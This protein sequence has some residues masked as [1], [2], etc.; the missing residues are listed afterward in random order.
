MNKINNYRQ[1]IILFFFSILFISPSCAA[2]VLRLSN[3]QTVNKNFDNRFGPDSAYSDSRTFYIYNDGNTSMTISSVT[4]DGPGYGIT[5]SIYSSPNSISAGGSGAITVSFNVPSSV[6]TGT[7]TGVI[8]VNTVSGGSGT[9]KL[10][11]VVTTKIPAELGSIGSRSVTI[12]FDKPKGSVPSFQGNESI[13]L[14][15]IGDSILYIDSIYVS[16]PNSDI[17]LSIS[18]YQTPISPKDS[19][20]A[21][22]VITAQPSAREGT[23][24]GQITVTTSKEGRYSGKYGTPKTDNVEVRVTIEHGINMEI[25][26]SSINFGDTELLKQKEDYI[27]I[28]ETLGYK[29]IKDIKITKSGP[30]K[31]LSVSP[32]S[33]SSINAFGSERISAKLLYEGDAEPYINHEWMYTIST[34]NAGSKS[35]KVSSKMI[36]DPIVPEKICSSKYKSIDD[37]KEIAEKMCSALGYGINTAAKTFKIS[38]LIL[39]FSIGSS[40]IDLLDSYIIAE[41][42]INKEEH[43]TAYEN[44][45]KGVVSA[46]IINTYAEKI[47]DYNVKLD[48]NFVNEKS[49]NLMNSLLEKETNYYESKKDSDSL[50]SLQ[51]MIAYERLSEMWGVLGNDEKQVHYDTLAKEKFKEHNNYVD[52]AKD[53]RLEAENLLKETQNNY[54]SKWGG[55]YLLINPFYYSTVS[56]EHNSIVSKYEE[57]TQNY[58]LAGEKAIADKTKERLNDIESLFNKIYSIFFVFTGFYTLAFLG[59]LSRSTKAMTAFVRDTSETR[60]GD[61]FL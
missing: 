27:D 43:D 54:L 36:F 58:G 50:D 61:D 7:Y 1:L 18:G 17:T 56:R 13:T 26:K 34:I 9:M 8:N 28:S 20:M 41:D 12:K 51:S 48:V 14:R 16:N 57:A 47:S 29:S 2:P 40:T 52:S 10:V 6:S 45:I 46:K 35:F 4:V 53:S 60:M 24:N 59:V 33:L 31:W 22:L 39:L 55:M 44:L 21:T 5:M 49:S 42:S 11:L 19:T 37:T 38:E 30:N 23:F 32:N 3:D 25:T 15:N